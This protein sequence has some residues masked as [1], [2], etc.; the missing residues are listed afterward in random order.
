MTDVR[1]LC[2]VFLGSL[3]NPSEQKVVSFKLIVFFNSKH[4]GLHY[5][6][7]NA[8]ETILCSCLICEWSL[9]PKKQMLSHESRS[10]K[11]EPS[12]LAPAEEE[13]GW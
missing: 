1:T 5:L 4:L 12:Y 6:M 7:S 10:F 8:L 3:S 11:S 9:N 13:Q 2:P